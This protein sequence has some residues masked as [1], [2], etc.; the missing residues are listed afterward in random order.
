MALPLIQAQMHTKGTKG[1]KSCSA[2]MYKAPKKG[3]KSTKKGTGYG[4][5]GKR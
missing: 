1:N 5:K 4:S 2:G 3:K